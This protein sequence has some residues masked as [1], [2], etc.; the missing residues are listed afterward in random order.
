MHS[1]HA[2]WYLADGLPVH[3]PDA[4][5]AGHAWTMSICFIYRYI[6][7]CTAAGCEVQAHKR[8]LTMGFTT[9]SMAVINWGD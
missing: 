8:V 1:D 7:M 4:N 3:D 6:D 5:S 2:I 9:I